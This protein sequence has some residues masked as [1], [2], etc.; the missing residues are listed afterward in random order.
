ML[1]K[2]ISME[3]GV[4]AQNTSEKRIGFKTDFSFLRYENRRHVLAL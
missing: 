3:Q 4:T 1:K 2:R